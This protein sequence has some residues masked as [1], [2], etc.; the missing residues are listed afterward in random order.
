MPQS[1][2]VVGQNKVAIKKEAESIAQEFS[3][4]FDTLTFDTSESKGIDLV[5]DIITNS[6]RKPFNSKILTI[7]ILEADKLTLEAQNSLL[8]LLEEP[9]NQTQIILTTQNSDKLLPT[10]VSRCLKINITPEANEKE[11]NDI[12]FEDFFQKTFVARLDLLEKYGVEQYLEFL[13]KKLRE[14]VLNQSEVLN[15]STKEISLKLKIALKLNKAVKSSANKKLV[16]LILAQ[17]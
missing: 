4:T 12:K 2:V 5:R 8:K 1:L 9:P 16:A 15:T 11:T 3:S 14:T 7:I 10:V 17:N 13:E 6:F